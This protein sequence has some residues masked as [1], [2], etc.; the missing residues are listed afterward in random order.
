MVLSL[1]ICLEFLI[2][3]AIRN[4]ERKRNYVNRTRKNIFKE[5]WNGGADYGAGRIQ[6]DSG[7]GSRG[8]SL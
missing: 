2:K 4:E 5:I 8:T 3:S 1:R 6:C 7:T